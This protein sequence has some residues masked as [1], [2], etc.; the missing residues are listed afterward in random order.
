MKLFNKDELLADELRYYFI[1]NQIPAGTKL[2]SE[3]ELAEQYGVQRAT[4]RSAY[5]ILEGEGIIE[6]RERSGRYMRHAR[7]VTN[8]RQI[9]SFSD[10]LN[11]MGMQMDNK[12]LAF[13]LIE[14]DKQLSKKIKLPIGTALS[15]ITRV[16]SILLDEKPL[17][18]SI[19]YAYIPESAADKLM[20]YDLEEHSLFHIL[21]EKY[22][23]I[24][25]REEQV[26]EIVYASE[27]EAK[28]LRVNQTTALVLKE[29]TTYD[30]EGNLLQFLHA[31]MN[32]DWVSFEQGNE[33]IR[34][35]MRGV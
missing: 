4:A 25:K 10:K 19:E 3:R 32:K 24:P 27:F 15:K 31:V 29:G 12:L 13:E 7:I 33:R 20:K 17:P 5:Q 26:I 21:Q 14:V 8:L 9:R 28:V 34:E 30:E 18:I 35:K 22:G 1:K 6:N 23:R 2:P 16:R 11:H